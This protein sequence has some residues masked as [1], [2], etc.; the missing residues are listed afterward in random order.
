MGRNS[1]TIASL[2][3]NSFIF[4]DTQIQDIIVFNAFQS[5]KTFLYVLHLYT[6]HNCVHTV[7]DEVLFASVICSV[8][9][10]ITSEHT[11]VTL[12]LKKTKRSPVCSLS[13]CW[14]HAA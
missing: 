14:L 7:L 2:I 11:V 3:I 13:V 12:T 4:G 5:K 10:T 1:L 8:Y 9:I 6:L